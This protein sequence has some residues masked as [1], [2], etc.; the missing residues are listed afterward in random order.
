MEKAFTTTYSNNHNNC[1]KD[2]DINL[3]LYQK[4]ESIN[5]RLVRKYYG[6]VHPLV[7][8]IDPHN[9]TVNDSNHNPSLSSFAFP[10]AA[11]WSSNNS[12]SSSNKRSYT[13]IST[14]TAN[15]ITT[16]HEN[17][18]CIAHTLLRRRHSKTT[19]L[20]MSIPYSWYRFPPSKR[21]SSLSFSDTVS[22]VKHNDD[23]GVC[24]N[25][26]SK[27][28]TTDNTVKSTNINSG[29]ESIVSHLTTQVVQENNNCNDN[30][31][32]IDNNQLPLLSST[33]K[34][35]QQQQQQQQTIGKIRIEPGQQATI[36]ELYDI[37]KSTI[38][39]GTLPSGIE[40]YYYEKKT[41]PPPPISLLDE[42]DE[43]E[44][45]ECV[46]VVRYK[47]ALL[48]VDILDNNTATTT[49]TSFIDKNN[50]NNN[51]EIEYPLVG[52]ISDRG[53]FADDP[54]LIL[55]EI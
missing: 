42:D 34:Q 27:G 20:G 38:I 28:I 41:L 54:Y 46:A 49:T 11:Q 1:D 37:D 13:E 30:A 3:V 35:Q 23:S 33:I 17:Y 15:P 36:R 19:G 2:N 21:R 31:T 6:I 50:D 44:E 14:T 32:V 18:D 47:V 40:R 51:S 29:L 52:W 53:R 12:G 39:I 25:D 24:N 26:V 43:E 48:P 22:L 8:R 55:R 4:N 10:S 5:N 7:G 9:V 45:D 16:L